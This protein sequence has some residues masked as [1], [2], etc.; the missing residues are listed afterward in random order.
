[1]DDV[2]SSNPSAF[3]M[4]R[5]FAN[6]SFIK[7]DDVENKALLD[8]IL[9]RNENELKKPNNIIEVS[10]DV[11]ERIKE[12]YKDDYKITANNILKLASNGETIKHEMAIEAG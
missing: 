4:L 3:K 6:L 10:K 11:H 5:V 8:I 1:M 9:K 12:I 7:I 2:L